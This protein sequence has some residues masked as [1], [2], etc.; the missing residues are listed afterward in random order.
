MFPLRRPAV[1]RVLPALL[2]L[3]AA[4]LILAQNG[5]GL[6]PSG[7]GSAA[8]ND[9]VIWLSDMQPGG[10]EQPARKPPFMR[11]WLRL[12]AYPQNSAF[13]RDNDDVKREV[14]FV[15]PQGKPEGEPLLP[16]SDKGRLNLT[17]AMPTQGLYRV[18]V[19]TRKLQGKTLDVN[20]SK[21]EFRHIIYSIRDKYEVKHLLRNVR[22]EEKQ[23]RDLVANRMLRSAPI[24]IVRERL[25]YE[26][27]PSLMHSGSKQAF[28]VLIKGVPAP[29]V[30]VRFVSHK[31]WSKKTVSDGQGR[32]SLQLIQDYY[33]LRKRFNKGVTLLIIARANVAEA[34]NYKGR[35]YT[36]V[37]YQAVLADNYNLPR[38]DYTSHALG[39][40][41]SFLAVLACGAG[42]YLSRRRDRFSRGAYADDDE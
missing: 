31:G 24:E 4:G 6:P 39:L 25:P 3:L 41:I 13:C 23:A 14:I 33:P 8:G 40:W 17:F 12:G 7:G 28:F 11:L 20:V 42:V 9:E 26:R 15:T 37:N 10:V 19:T 21:L 38:E 30:Q 1:H 16:K 18:Y 5:N 35:P 32:V 22:S 2:V 36:R 34:G 29:G 27:S